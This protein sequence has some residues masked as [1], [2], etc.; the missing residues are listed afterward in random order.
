VAQEDYYAD[1]TEDYYRAAENYAEAVR[2]V[3][4]GG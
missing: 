4:S 3:V 1:A 2:L